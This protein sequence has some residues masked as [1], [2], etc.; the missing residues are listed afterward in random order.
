MDLVHLD[1]LCSDLTVA[2][3]TLKALCDDSRSHNPDEPFR[4]FIQSPVNS[5]DEISIT[6]NNLC[7]IATRLETLLAGPSCFI[8]RM[9]YQHELLACLKWL[10]E[11]Q[12]IA[13][14]PL[15]E[16]ISFE[17]LAELADVSTRTL[18]RVVRMTATAGF[19]HEPQIG[20]V[21]HTPLSSSFT[22]ELVYFDAT[23]FLANRVAPS[24]LNIALFPSSQ[25][26][27]SPN[28]IALKCVE[29]FA[30]DRAQEP[31]LNRQWMAYCDSVGGIKQD[32]IV[33]ANLLN[34]HTLGEASVVHICD[35]YTR[36]SWA[37]ARVSSALRV[38][39]QTYDYTPGDSAVARPGESE[40]DSAVSRRVNIS[41]RKPTTQQ[42]VRDAAVYIVQPFFNARST[43]GLTPQELLT[44]ELKSH[45]SILQA[46]PSAV[47]ILAPAMLP[48][49]GSVAVN[50]EVQA[51]ILDFVEMRLNQRSAVE[52]TELFQLT[53]SICDAHGRLM[54][55]NR[56]RS[57][58]GATVGLAVQYQSFAGPRKLV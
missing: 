9:A 22:N 43:D 37:L 38:I 25:E 23:M 44:T 32:V 24:A 57:V 46:N 52:V 29:Q 40:E 34:W 35:R 4:D 26:N 55:T 39:V 49:P 27:G 7:G 45:Y 47:L 14:V 58:D 8:R 1:A 36:A 33:L 19:L 28:K 21:A 51:R 17:E 54:V 53:E 30:S 12:I 50:L 18:S 6:R 16:S 56:L 31:Q 42:A 11:Y 48:E 3:K 2:A 5:Q 20:H 15:S 10:G 13:Y 41:R